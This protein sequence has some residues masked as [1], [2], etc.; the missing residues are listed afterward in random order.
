M[1]ANTIAAD[2]FGTWGVDEAKDLCSRVVGLGP[3]LAQIA[4]GFI[5]YGWVTWKYRKGREN[6]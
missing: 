6:P 4:F 3:K 5:V 2:A 1:A